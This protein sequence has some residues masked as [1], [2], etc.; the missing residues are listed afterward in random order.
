MCAVRLFFAV[1][2]AVVLAAPV[3][4]GT[5]LDQNFVTTDN[6]NSNTGVG[7]ASSSLAQTFT[8]G[9]DGTLAAVEFNILKNSE[10]VFDLTVDIRTL[11]GGAPDPLAANALGTTTVAAADIGTFNAN[12]YP[13]TSIRVDFGAA[14]IAVSAG[15]ML[16]FVLTGGPYGVQT[17]YTDSYAG[18]QRWSQS[19]Y[20]N[21][22]GV[23]ATA[24]LAFKTYVDV[25][26]VPIPAALPLLATALAGLGLAAWRARRTA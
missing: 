16:A 26:A 24:D 11:I 7:L 19:G 6:P 5:V 18:G 14:G 4:A 21:P 17:D 1:L 15:D 25:A 9:L 23:L 8:V 12:P 13:W 10:P 3:S 2:V 22:F 20:G